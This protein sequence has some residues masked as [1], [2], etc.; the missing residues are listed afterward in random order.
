M[1]NRPGPAAQPPPL[2]SPLGLTARGF[3]WRHAG[4]RAWALKDV[5]FD[6]SPGERV[7]LLGTSGCGKSTLLAAAAGLFGPGIPQP[8]G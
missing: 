7:L 1:T 8:G 3:G 5:D 6:I 2:G 4:R